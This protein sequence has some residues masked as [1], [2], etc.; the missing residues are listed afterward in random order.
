MVSIVPMNFNKINIFM[1]IHIIL[2][3]IVVL[4]TTAYYKTHRLISLQATN[5][6]KY[7]CVTVGH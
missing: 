7:L 6:Y 1:N 4:T 3:G 5:I 2:Y